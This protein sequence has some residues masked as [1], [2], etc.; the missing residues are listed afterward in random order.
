MK[1]ILL[2]AGNVKKNSTGAAK[3]E[4]I[5]WNFVFDIGRIRNRHGRKS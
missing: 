3:F 1:G 2:P 5:N 4:I